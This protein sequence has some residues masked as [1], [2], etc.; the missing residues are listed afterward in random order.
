MQMHAI[1]EGVV[2][3]WNIWENAGFM[4]VYGY[5]MFKDGREAKVFYPTEGF[6]SEVSGRS[7]HNGETGWRNTCVDRRSARCTLESCFQILSYACF[8]LLRRPLCAAFAAG[9]SRVVHSDSAVR[10]CQA[11]TRWCAACLPHVCISDM[12]E[13][14]ADSETDFDS[15][16]QHAEHGSFVT[17]SHP[18]DNAEEGNEWEDGH[19]VTGVAYSSAALG[20]QVATAHLTVRVCLEAQS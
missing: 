19:V 18:V 2:R 15:A 13:M 11:V 12:R 14:S 4:Q 5:C 17:A 16:S 8:L 1:V 10:H 7:F 9:G 3:L 20:D 6:S